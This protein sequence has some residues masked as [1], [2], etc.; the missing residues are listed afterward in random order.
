MTGRA[1]PARP[2]RRSSRLLAAILAL[3][4]VVVGFA[5]LMM[6]LAVIRE[7][8]RMAALSKDIARA[9]NENRGLELK[10]AELSSQQRLRALAPR[11][12]LEPPKPRQVVMMP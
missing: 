10:V 5:T 12:G 2:S 11:F 4:I 6:R 9:Q 8:Y 7:G 1:K 3:A